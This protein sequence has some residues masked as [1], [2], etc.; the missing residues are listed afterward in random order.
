MTQFWNY[1]ISSPPYLGNG[2]SYRNSKFGT[3]RWTPRGTKEKNEKI[4]LMGVTR[5]LRDQIL[6]LW[7]PLR[8]WGTVEAR[9]SKCGTQM[10]PSGTKE[11]MKN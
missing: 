11:K 3:Y 6:E 4:R 8:I 10:D 7:D 5:E 9:N 2:K 1:G